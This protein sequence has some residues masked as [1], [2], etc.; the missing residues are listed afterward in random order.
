MIICASRRTDI[1]AFHSEWLMNRLRAGYV[2]VRNPIYKAIVYKI[3][4]TPRNVDCLLF[5]TKDP[6]PLMP[7]LKDIAKMGYMYTFQV[8]ITPYGNNIEPGVPFKADIADAFKQISEKIGSDRIL[9]RYD[10]ILVNEN[11]NI[12]YHKRKFELLCKELEGYTDR[13]TFSFIDM[14]GKLGKLSEAGVLRSVTRSEMDV[15][16]KEMSDISMKY[17]IR[18][19]YCCAKYDLSKYGI[20][21]RGCIDRETMRLLNIPFEDMTMP[22]RE[23]CRCVKNIDIGM[24]DTC[25]HD[26]VYCY[27]NSSDREK[28]NL[29]IFDPENEMLYGFLEKDDRI[30]ELSS[31]TIGRINDY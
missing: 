27:A 22:L 19:S 12:G 28:R 2:L 3:D 20:E 23:G 24:Y 8:T 10:P 31:R 6:R 13:C 11:F 30:V 26:C 21:P 16:G 18:L 1:P 7:Y 15:L 14:Y 25:F 17:G 9:W 29:K 5:I 4:L